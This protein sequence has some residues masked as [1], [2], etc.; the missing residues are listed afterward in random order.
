MSLFLYIY[1]YLFWDLK[2]FKATEYDTYLYLQQY[3][4]TIPNKK[5]Q[6]RYKLYN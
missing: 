4:L 5:I 1:K 6:H 2:D 3:A